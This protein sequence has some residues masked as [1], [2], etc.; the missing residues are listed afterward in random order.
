MTNLIS[1]HE[2][3]DRIIVL[4]D[5]IED[6]R[7]DRCKLHS[8]TGILGI[9]FCGNIAGL[10]DLNDV[11]IF[12]NERVEWFKS[13]LSLENGIPCVDTF[14]R[15]LRVL[16][17]VYLE[18]V[19]SQI[20][21][22]IREVLEHANNHIAIDGK[23]IRGSVDGEKKAIHSVSA[24]CTEQ[25]IVLA[26]V[27]TEEK[28]NE[29]TAIPE[30]LKLVDIKEHVVSLDAMGCQKE[31]ASQIIKQKG[32]YYLSVKLNQPTL[33][34]AINGIVE[35]HVS[36]DFSGI[37]HVFHETTDKEHGR[38][39][40]RR[41]WSMDA[42]LL[43]TYGFSALWEQ[44]KSIGIIE[45]KV[46]QGDTITT[47]YAYVISSRSPN[48]KEL[49]RTVRDHWK[50]ES[51]HWMLD[52]HFREDASRI[53]KDHGPE[54]MAILRRLAYNLVKKVTPAKRTFK[55]TKVRALLNTNVLE[56]I[57]KGQKI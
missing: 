12:A 17:P 1:I 45:R 31:I 44:L 2:A 23:T 53:R 22:E 14:R 10:T 6:P 54:N 20:S 25:G 13:F 16:N 11:V 9:L 41:H 48:A 3:Y 35:R 33:Y 8:L 27:K 26:Q 55:S 15:V 5:E 30:L 37:K 32:D 38:L 56:S 49:A 40:V 43:G 29:I 28:S 46:E 52:V 7:I 4:F 36:T 24:Y 18:G 34:E 51:F 50:I 47:S 57:I 19:F 42:S 21:Q 39:E